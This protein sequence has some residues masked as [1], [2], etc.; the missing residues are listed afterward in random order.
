M[1]LKLDIK[2]L[3]V[4]ALALVQAEGRL[5]QAEAAEKIVQAQRGAVL[6]LASLILILIAAF[7]LTQSLIDWI[8]TL[9]GE[10]PASRL[11]SC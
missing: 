4:D 2:A 10:A 3:Y 5:I 11:V 7:V 1:S 8:A 9:I 6:L